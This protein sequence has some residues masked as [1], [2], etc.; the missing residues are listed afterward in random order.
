MSKSP[1]TLTNDEAFKLIDCL[2]IG[3]GRPATKPKAVRNATIALLMLDAGLRVGEVVRLKPYDLFIGGK[4]VSQ[5]YVSPDIAEKGCTRHIPLS[6]RLRIAVEQMQECWWG[7]S[8]ANLPPSAFYTS[9]DFCSI[10]IRQIERIISKSSLEAFGR[11]IHPHILRHTFAT[12]LSRITSMRV[13]QDL[14]GHKQ[15]SSTQIY[16]H[17]NSEDKLAAIAKLETNA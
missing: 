4:P 16:L 3:F 15:L 6:T 8:T 17:P 13:V 9:S 2:M 14:L 12:N 1:E 5:L 11:K 7:S 10:S